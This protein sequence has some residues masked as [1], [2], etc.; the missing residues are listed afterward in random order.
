MKDDLR[1][2]ILN[3]FRK[4]N[5]STSETRANDWLAKQHSDLGTI[6]RSLVDLVDSEYIKLSSIGDKNPKEWLETNWDSSTSGART[7][8]DNDKK[9]AQRLI[10]KVG[11]HEKVKDVR[12]YTTVKGLTF[13]AEYNRFK[14]FHL[15]KLLYIVIGIVLGFLITFMLERT[16][17]NP[18]SNNC[19]KRIEKNAP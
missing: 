15:H 7:E 13:I 16:L 14:N 3:H 6:R 17:N 1:I 8:D 18:E 9:S 10:R 11:N 2:K 19:P 12:L 4:L 5:K